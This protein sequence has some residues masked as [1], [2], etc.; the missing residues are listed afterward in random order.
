MNEWTKEQIFR[1]QNK[2]KK[3]REC[4]KTQR[5]SLN[6]YTLDLCLLNHDRQTIGQNNVLTQYAYVLDIFP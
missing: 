2:G 1:F 5:K 6:L 4:A 3:E